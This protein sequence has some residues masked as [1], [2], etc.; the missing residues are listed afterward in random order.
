MFIKDAWYS[1]EGVAS[2]GGMTGLNNLDFWKDREP[3][4]FG[5]TYEAYREQD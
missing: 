3:S 5:L 4:D 2:H 1:S